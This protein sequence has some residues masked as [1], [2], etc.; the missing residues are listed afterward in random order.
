MIT[1]LDVFKD[2]FALYCKKNGR[3]EIMIYDLD[4]R[5]F[6]SIDV[7]EDVGEILP[8]LNQDYDSKQLS[9]MFS[10]PFIYNQQYRYQHATK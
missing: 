4:K 10:S 3:P 5:E 9:F 8:G 1:E 7:D 6:Q 2:F